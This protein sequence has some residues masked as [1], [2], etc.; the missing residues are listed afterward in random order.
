MQV[1]YIGLRRVLG[2]N[3]S[4]D[5]KPERLETLLRLGYERAYFEATRLFAAFSEWERRN[6]PF[7]IAREACIS[8]RPDGG[9]SHRDIASEWKTNVS[10]W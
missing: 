7:V 3:N 9:E 1:L 6:A 2:R 10:L 8:V 4:A 5:V